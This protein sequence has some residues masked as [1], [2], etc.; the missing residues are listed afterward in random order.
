MI[1][2]HILNSSFTVALHKAIENMPKITKKHQA[3][4]KTSFDIETEDLR[5]DIVAVLV[6][7]YVYENWICCSHKVCKNHQQ[8]TRCIHKFNRFLLTAYMLKK[9]SSH[10]TNLMT[11]NSLKCA[12]AAARKSVKKLMTDSTRNIWWTIFNILLEQKASPFTSHVT[13]RV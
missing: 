13:H 4:C 3:T 7:V 10:I 12:A 6:C 11:L 9:I 5:Q 8:A 2:S 1:S